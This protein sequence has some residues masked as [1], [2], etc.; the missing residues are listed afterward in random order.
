MEIEE[1]KK[2]YDVRIDYLEDCVRIQI[3]ET[4]TGEIYKELANVVRNYDGKIVVANGIMGKATKE[5]FLKGEE[6]IDEIVAEIN[7]EWSKKQKAAY[8]H[9]KMGE[10]ITYAPDFHFVGKYA[11]DFTAGT[12][13]IWKSL[14]DGKS[15]C[16][17][18][19][20]IQRNILARVGVNTRELSSDTHSFLLVETEEGNIITDATWDLSN[21]LFKARPMYFGKTYEQL[22]EPERNLSN[23]HKLE[24]P[25][26]N[27][28]G[29]SD[30]ELREIYHSIGL[31][32]EDRTF[33]YPIFEKF[34][35]VNS[36]EFDNLEQKIDAFLDMF[37]Q[38]FSEEATHLS[39]SRTMLE[40]CIYEF[41]IDPKDL[42]TKF[43]YTKDDESCEE[44]YLAFHINDE[45]MKN[46][47]K[48][49]DSKE[50]QFKDIQLKEFDQEYTVH[51]LDTVKPFWKRY[52]E[53]RQESQ[54][55]DIEEND[56]MI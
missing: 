20:S 15:V 23:A 25:P 46:Q 39:E 17:G 56:K 44:P 55:R 22:R 14:A 51:N 24:N 2:K 8:V 19:T 53:E 32:N 6:V 48:L 50:R 37:T 26:D 49:L 11:N 1:L 13:N 29:I 34:N 52:L 21:T 36:Q 9:Y 28:I 27:V 7:P 35:A 10:L 30:E 5:E 40:R 18:I 41:G 43:V 31:T 12:R 45:K 4:E 33:R 42:T 47:I 16:N 3:S 54:Q 38:N